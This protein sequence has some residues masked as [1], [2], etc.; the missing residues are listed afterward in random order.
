MRALW[1]PSMRVDESL[2]QEYLSSKELTAFRAMSRAEQLHSVQVLRIVLEQKAQ[3][4]RTLAAAALLHDVGKG[5]YHL[6]VWQK[7]FAVLVTALFP[8]LARSLGRDEGLALF[9]APFTVLAHHANWGGAILRCHGSNP[10]VVWL[11]E[12]HEDNHERWRDHAY[13]DLLQ[14]LQ[15]ADDAC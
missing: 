5:R 12:H 8:S 7:T 11:V 9:H 4:P 13:S 3:T 1:A 10:E 2:A 15:S 6:A 14:R